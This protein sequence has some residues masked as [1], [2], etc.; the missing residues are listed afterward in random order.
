MIPLIVPPLT[1][2]V[3]LASSTSGDQHFCETVALCK[4]PP[5]Q[6]W[7]RARA[8]GT[9]FARDDKKLGP[10]LG[11]NNY[12]ENGLVKPPRL[13]TRALC[14][15]EVFGVKALLRLA[16]QKS[17]PHA[18]LA[19]MRSAP[20]YFFFFFIFVNGEYKVDYTRL[21]LADKTIGVQVFPTR[22]GNNDT[23]DRR[24]IVNNMR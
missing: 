19:P 11:E 8:A 17:R 12:P 13:D 16:A 3:A 23:W 7:G 22:A 24:R 18:L 9:R 6:D 14:R 21:P 1:L 2:P 10:Q 15:A 4:P 5:L 20:A